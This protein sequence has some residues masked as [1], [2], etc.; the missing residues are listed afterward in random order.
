MSPKGSKILLVCLLLLRWIEW[1][2]ALKQTRV[3]VRLSI[4]CVRIHKNFKQTRVTEEFEIRGCCFDWKNM[5]SSEERVVAVIM[6]GGPTKG[7]IF[8]CSFNCLI[9]VWFLYWNSQLW[10]LNCMRYSLMLILWL[11]YRTFSWVLLIFSMFIVILILL[12]QIMKPCSLF[13]DFFSS[14]NWVEIWN[15]A[16]TRFRPLS[17]DIPKPLFPLAGQPMVHHPI[18]AC[19]KVFI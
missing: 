2:H 17:L 7:I 12:V 1:W 18:S 9:T 16:G 3:T 15:V 11:H 4:A 13:F 5:G 8:F 10:F 19:K 6:V 14:F